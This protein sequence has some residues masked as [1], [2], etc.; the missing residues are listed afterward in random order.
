MMM[1][2][3][4]IRRRVRTHRMRIRRPLAVGQAPEE[5]V[6]K[7]VFGTNHIGYEREGLKYGRRDLWNTGLRKCLPA[8]QMDG[9]KESKRNKR[10]THFL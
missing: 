3:T 10:Q 9:D 4:M 6:R 1:M 2:S 5:K 7:T 8:V